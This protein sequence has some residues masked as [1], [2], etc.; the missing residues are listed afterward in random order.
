MDPAVHVRIEWIIRSLRSCINVVTVHADESIA[1][2]GDVPVTVKDVLA[3]L[4]V[5][6]AVGESLIAR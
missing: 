2:P 3:I 1:L 4:V 5:I 6:V